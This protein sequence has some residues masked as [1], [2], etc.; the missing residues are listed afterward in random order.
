MKLA[1]GVLAALVCSCAIA[2]ET[3]TRSLT[4]EDRVKA[5]EA[6][7]RVYYAHRT[8]VT[9]S[10]EKAVPRAV[11]EGK[12]RRYLDQTEALAL[13]RNVAVTDEMLQG[14]LRRMGAGSRMPD[15]LLELYAALGDDT[16]LIKECLARATLVERLTRESTAFDTSL[17]KEAIGRQVARAIT[18]S[19]HRRSEPA[20]TVSRV[21]A[22]GAVAA[23]QGTICPIDD[24]WSPTSGTNAPSPRELHSAIWT[25]AEMIVWGG[26]FY[27]GTSYVLN[28]GRRYDPATDSWTPTSTTGSPSHRALHTAVW[29]GSRMVVWGGLGSEGYLSSGGRY[30][31]ATDSWVPTSM[32]GAPA[33]R[34]DHTAVWTGSRMVV[35]G[36]YYYDGAD[37]ELN[38]G[39]RYDPSTD[40]WASTSTGANVP[41]AR[42]LH[43]AVWTGS[44]MVVWGGWNGVDLESTGGRYDPVANT[45]A[46]TSTTDVP[47]GVEL[48]T[49]VWTGSRMVVWGGW[50][51][52]GDVGTG[53]RYD[54]VLDSWTYTSP[55][56][57]PS[58][59]DS[60][61]A[62]WTGSRMVVWG[63]GFYDGFDFLAV[64]TGAWYDPAA[65]SWTPMSTTGAPAA[66]FYHTAVWTGALMIV[67]GGEDAIDFFDTGGTYTLGTSVDN[68]GDGL[69]VCQGD[70]DDSDSAIYPGAIEACNGADDNCDAVIDNG[71]DA[72]C[73]DAS[74][75]TI[76]VCNGAAGCS[77]DTTCSDPNACTVESC[78]PASG[79]VYPTANMDSTGFSA[80]RVDGRDL[81]ILADA[82]NS[83]A[84][85]P[86]PTRYDPAADLDPANPCIEDADFHLFM[87]TFGRNCP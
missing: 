48:H 83:C 51:G 41:S 36:G 45:W 18:G 72:L 21:A 64:D 71:G 73:D 11:L 39:G 28:S 1:S 85:D 22:P 35:W 34:I 26:Y 25:G 78:I 74:V 63:G 6:V 79:C 82:W 81:V 58:P 33:G 46:T 23:P 5:Q 15:R 60:H 55:V 32:T 4:F 80:A 30:D 70:C 56:D 16:F 86:I 9:E 38:T 3:G 67:W 57:A 65:D 13:N 68:D 52:Y 2:G 87:T 8:G 43:T 66:R 44:L 31:P 59:R 84:S 69:S 10:F 29:T 50:D 24:L 49:A 17:H 42:D 77:N 27:D 54:P 61:S 62:V 47:A 37:H 53:G 14:E 76:D 19:R 40:T 20:G 75:C 7:E 12:V